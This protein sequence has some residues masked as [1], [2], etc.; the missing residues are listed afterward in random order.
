MTD[1]SS[2]IGRKPSEVPTGHMQPLSRLPVFYALHGKR[3]VLAGGSAAAAWKAELFCATGAQVHVFAA[4]SS[5]EM[6]DTVA[7]SAN[8]SLVLHQRPWQADDLN[9][10]VMAIGAFDSDADASAFAAAA[11]LVRVAVNVVDKPAFCDFSFGAIV[12]RSPLV[13]AVSTDGAAPVFAQAIRAKIEAMLPA[14]FAIWTQA[15]KDW[16]PLLKKFGLSF[17][18]RRQF[19]NLFTSLAL[20]KP[21]KPPKL[22]DLMRMVDGVRRKGVTTDQGSVSLVGAGPGEV[23]PVSGTEWR[24]C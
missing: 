19:W 16:R 2:E 23:V 20:R 18:A 6:R 1:L 24:L 9:G 14:G 3:V 13:I 11:R 10:A 5:E 22:D 21:N 17:N 4:D 8:G 15:A 12:N 7:R